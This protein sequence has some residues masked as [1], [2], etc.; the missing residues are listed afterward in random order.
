MP[1]GGAKELGESGKLAQAS[2]SGC[3]GVGEIQGKGSR[4]ER[5][6]KKEHQAQ[7]LGSFPP[8]ADKNKAETPSKRCSALSGCLPS[9]RRGELCD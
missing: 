5:R 2:E 4:K 1:E 8:S 9:S 7:S 3:A 6:Q